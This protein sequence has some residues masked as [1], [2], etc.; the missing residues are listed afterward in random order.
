[1]GVHQF[2]AYAQDA[3]RPVFFERK[4]EASG[5]RTRRMQWLPMECCPEDRFVLD[6]FSGRFGE[7]SFIE[8]PVLIFNLNLQLYPI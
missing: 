5:Q 4:Q 7:I 6:I 2:D 8:M 1:M 3:K